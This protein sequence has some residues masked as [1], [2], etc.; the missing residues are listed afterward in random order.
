MVI[1]VPDGCTVSV[2]YKELN[3]ELDPDAI[4]I[5]VNDQ[6]AEET[7]VLIAGD[8]IHLV[9]AISGG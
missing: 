2:L 6:L 3:I 1:E 8:Q 4:L 5:V 9:P 7:D